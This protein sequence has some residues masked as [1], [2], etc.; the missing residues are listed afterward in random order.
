MSRWKGRIKEP[1]AMIPIR[2]MICS[3]YKTL[4][5]GFQRVL[6]ILAAQYDGTNNGDLS[7]TRKMGRHFGLNN[8]RCRS[9]GLRELDERGLIQKTLQ[10]G[11]SYGGQKCPTLWA[12]TWRPIDYFDGRK[13]EAVRLP[14]E[15]W[16]NWAGNT[17]IACAT[18]RKT[19][20]RNGSPDTQYECET[21]PPPTRKL[22][23]P[24]KNLTGSEV[25][26]G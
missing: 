25:R 22:R 12:L 8:E 26:Q 6:W 14:A 11:L 24:S 18:T 15:S 3:A 2:V 16:R 19:R 1:F 9:R 10:G 21:P 5:A 4:P 7:L 20:A 13:L 17:Q 23:A